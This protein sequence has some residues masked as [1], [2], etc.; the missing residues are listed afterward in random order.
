[1]AVQHKFKM[2]TG[3]KVSAV[4]QDE[5]LL[6]ILAKAVDYGSDFVHDLFLNDLSKLNQF[7]SLIAT[8]GESSWV[9]GTDTNT[10]FPIWYVVDGDSVLTI[11]VYLTEKGKSILRQGTDSID[12][13][14][15]IGF[16]YI[17]LITN[18][19]TQKQSISQVATNIVQYAGEG[20]PKIEAG[21]G[22]KNVIKN[23]VS[24]V[25]KFVKRVITL[26]FEGKVTNNP[27]IAQE[28]ATSNAEK[29]AKEASVQEETIPIS[30]GETIAADI[31]ISVVDAIG[32]VFSLGTLTLT[33]ILNILS[34]EI[35]SFVRF[36]N[37]TN[38]DLEFS[39]CWIKENVAV[40][41]SPML[42]Q[43]PI[44]IPKI[45]PAWTPPWIIGSDPISYIDMVFANTDKL[46][47]IGYVLKARPNNDFPGFNV[48]VNIPNSGDNSL[49]LSFVTNDVCNSYWQDHKDKDT[50]LTMSTTSGNYTL[51]IATN[52]V[53]GES[54]SPVDG[55]EGYNYE[56]L[57]ILEEFGTN[58]K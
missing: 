55:A 24:V 11:G 7:Y 53:K 23:T 39:I 6:D 19:G 16:A 52:Q 43:N 56:H 25:K 32:L 12:S 18:S 37:L 44:T 57:V 2:G 28:N 3:A 35:R 9:N 33:I 49:Q 41:V 36:Y 47:G 58:N 50:N 22:L 34:K 26:A 48:M 27:T 1:M 29:A 13:F 21:D 8:N 54:P 30:E 46:K 20:I 38:Q 14:Q 45:S 17:N 10:G 15:D 5:N 42:P 4:K 51:K 31:E 40:A